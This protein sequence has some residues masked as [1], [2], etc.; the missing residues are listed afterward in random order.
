M[1]KVR[2]HLLDY[3]QREV[4]LSMG[5]SPLSGYIPP[6]PIPELDISPEIANTE[7]ISALIEKDTPEDVY[8]SHELKETVADILDSLTPRECKVLKLRFGID[9]PND[10]TL[11]EVG[12]LMGC[13]KERV[14]QI[15]AK[16]LRKMRHPSRSDKLKSFLDGGFISTIWAELSEPMPEF[17]EEDEWDSAKA[18]TQRLEAWSERVTAAAKK[19]RE[20]KARLASGVTDYKLG[21]QE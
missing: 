11:E 17:D 10:W 15:E 8:I 4:L 20:A 12:K 7:E 2:K 21:E 5:L 19:I 16:A 14:R 13:T 9:M 18:Y 6:I 3:R 1:G